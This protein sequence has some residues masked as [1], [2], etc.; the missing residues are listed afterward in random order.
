MLVDND[1]DEPVDNLGNRG[2]QTGPPV[3]EV[4]MIDVT[5]RRTLRMTCTDARPPPVER[6]KI[7]D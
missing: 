2:I 6:R 7:R 1:V 3:H 4:W 5:G